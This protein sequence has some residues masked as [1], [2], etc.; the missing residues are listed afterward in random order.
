M[1]CGLLVVMSVPE[2]PSNA[3]YFLQT[4]RYR[5]DAPLMQIARN[6]NLGLRKE[7]K[8]KE[9]MKKIVK[10]RDPGPDLAFY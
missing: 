9:R 10:R 7:K 6:Q 1:W 4:R 3:F 8:L 5:N 2:P